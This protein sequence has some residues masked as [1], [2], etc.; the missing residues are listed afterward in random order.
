MYGQDPPQDGGEVFDLVLLCE[1]L[2]PHKWLQAPQ[3][4]QEETAQFLGLH[5]G[6]ARLRLLR[7][8]DSTS[9]VQNNTIKEIAKKTFFHIVFEIKGGRVEIRVKFALAK[10]LASGLRSHAVVTR[11]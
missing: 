3:E 10:R 5:G 6:G 9:R 7:R 11:C 4:D 2:V 8:Q 1:P